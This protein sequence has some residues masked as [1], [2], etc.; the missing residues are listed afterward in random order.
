MTRIAVLGATSGPGAA[1]ALKLVAQGHD[2]VGVGRDKSKMEALSRVS[3]GDIRWHACD[4]NDHPN[5]VKALDNAVVV[6]NCSNPYYVA[7]ILNALSSSAER[8]VILGSTRIFTKFPDE[9]AAYVSKAE[10]EAL[11]SGIP[12]TVLHP[13]LIYGW[14]GNNNI[15]R[16]VQLVRWF[17]F[18]PLPKS[19]RSLIQPIHNDDVAACIESA[20]M[21]DETIGKAIVIAGPKPISYAEFIRESAQAAGLKARV[22]GV[23]LGLAFLLA[24]LTRIL[25]GIPGVTKMEIKRLLE[26]KNFDISEMKTILGI[27][28]RPFE[29]GVKDLFN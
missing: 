11:S 18:I 28:P 13:S 9:R 19:G 4:L 15:G 6:I 7:R 26:D 17:R 27:H 3:K 25:P 10:A 14:K 1:L 21:N 12:A 2:V 24:A 29:E 22:F 20:L 16:I 5:L 23:P 8:F